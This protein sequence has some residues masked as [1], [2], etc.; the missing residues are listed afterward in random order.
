[1]NGIVKW[2]FTLLF[3]MLFIPLSFA[4]TEGSGEKKI[5]DAKIA[6]QVRSKLQSDKILDAFTL[7]V[8]AKHGVIYLKGKVDTHVELERATRLTAGIKGVKK[9]DTSQ[10]KLSNTEAAN[11]DR[12]I[13]AKLER[14][15][16]ES[17]HFSSLPHP[18]AAIK[19][20]TKKGIVYLSGAV[21]N[22]QQKNELQRQAESLPGVIRIENDLEIA[23]DPGY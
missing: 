6:R 19:I 4:I 14:F 16:K 5:S 23:A 22:Q 11:E 1:M 18:V 15:L 2:C 17:E 9:V 21:S 12:L 10:L 3:V 7:Q 20:Q 8:K 13:T